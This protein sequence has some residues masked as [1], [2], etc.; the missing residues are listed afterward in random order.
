MPNRCSGPTCIRMLWYGPGVVLLLLLLH[1]Y[2]NY[3]LQ[4]DITNVL[5]YTL[6]MVFVGSWHGYNW[7]FACVQSHHERRL[8]GNVIRIYLL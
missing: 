8:T 7:N 5:I 6:F 4:N 3:Y 2:Y 1:H